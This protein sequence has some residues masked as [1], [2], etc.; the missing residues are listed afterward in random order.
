LASLYRRFIK[1]LNTI[2]APLTEIVKKILGFKW[3]IGQEKTFNLL[4][5]KLI[6]APLLVLLNFTKTFEIECDASCIDIR[7]VLTQ[8][9]RSMT[10]LSKKVNGETLNYPH[11]IKSYIY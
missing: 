2:V 8:N 1:D 7:A 5:E 6:L 11:M 4:K 10:Y 9:K 3:E